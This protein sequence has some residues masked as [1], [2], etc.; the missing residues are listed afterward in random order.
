MITRKYIIEKVNR[1]AED[2][3]AKA[4]RTDNLEQTLDSVEE[5]EDIQVANFVKR[6]LS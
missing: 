3:K 6:S 2:T 1:K 4:K 5:E